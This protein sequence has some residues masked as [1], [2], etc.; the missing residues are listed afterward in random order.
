MITLDDIHRMRDKLHDMG[1][2]PPYEL[3]VTSAMA[4]QMRDNYMLLGNM[5]LNAHGVR[6]K[7]D[8]RDAGVA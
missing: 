5:V 2:N 4:E 1:V 7:V 6:I 3:R 8:D